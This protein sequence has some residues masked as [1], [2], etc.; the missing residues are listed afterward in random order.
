MAGQILEPGQIEAAA[1]IPTFLNLPERDLFQHRAERLR[2]LAEG[3]PLAGYLL[4]I[5]SLCEAQQQVLDNP[6]K[7]PGPT[8]EALA[9]SREHRMPPL[10]FE[11]LVRA[12][13][14]LAAL[15]ALLAHF[16]TPTN[17]SV[18]VALR[19]L[20]EAD[21]GQRK[22]WGVGLL[23]GQFDLLPAALAPFLG[24]A[25]QV[26]FSHWLLALP[27]DTV[28]ETDTQTFCPACGSPP[29][30]GMIRHRGKQNGLRYLACSLCS[31]EWHYVRLKCSHCQESKHL[32]YLSLERDDA[33]AEQ[34]AIRAEA[35]PNCQG[36]LKQ[37]YLE[38]GAEAEAQADDL[39]SLD[40][41]L[42]LSEE[43]YLRRAP[44]L[45]LAPGG[46]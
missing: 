3:H 19:Q 10:A 24:A 6:P 41:D 21:E 22:A 17:P 37:C 12:D 43:G 13:G 1:N 42:R 20:A 18:A 35:C 11:T 27:E 7:L 9:R 14:W 25:L 40:L 2:R 16:K 46:E 15:D 34:A 5:A 23:N 32:A 38:Y 39:A 33:K 45:L 44:N 4:L 26:A 8:P 30:V 36:Y 31:C 28:V 29:V